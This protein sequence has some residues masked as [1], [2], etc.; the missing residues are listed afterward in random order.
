MGEPYLVMELLEGESLANR[1]D[2]EKTL[3]LSES[4][5]IAWQMALGLSAAHALGIVHRD[6]KPGNVFLVDLP[7]Q[8]GF[9]KLLDF[10]I[11]KG[12]GAQPQ[13]HPRIRHPRHA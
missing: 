2:R 5:R 11:S 7:T 10:G 13:D 4:V 1:L 3:S 12:T 9:V 6:L 8:K